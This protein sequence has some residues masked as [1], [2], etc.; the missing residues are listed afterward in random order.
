MDLNDIYSA[1]ALSKSQS[2]E[3]ISELNEYG[4]V[5]LEDY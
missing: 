1:F 5:K 4:V 2:D 3:E